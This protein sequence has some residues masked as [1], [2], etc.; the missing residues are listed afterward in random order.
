MNTK[1]ILKE[2]RYFLNEGVKEKFKESQIGEKVKIVTSCKK[3]ENFTGK[4]KG[5]EVKGDWTLKVV[6][7]EDVIIDNGKKEN[8]VIVTSG[9]KV[10]KIPQCCVDE[11]K[12][13]KS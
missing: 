1:E 5:E 7:A 8:L 9:N 13:E 12:D 2:W 6:N 4:D 3:C 11:L 10:K